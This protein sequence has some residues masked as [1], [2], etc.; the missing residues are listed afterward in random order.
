MSGENAIKLTQLVLAPGDPK[1]MAKLNDASPMPLDAALNLLR[2]KQNVIKMDIPISGNIND[3]NID[4]SDAIGQAIGTIAGKAGMAALTTVGPAAALGPIGLVAIV[5]KMGVDQLAKVRLASI[6]YAP[7]SSDRPANSDKALQD[8]ATVLEKKQELNLRLCPFYTLEDAQA[9]ASAAG[10]GN[11]QRSPLGTHQEAIAQL[12]K[13]RAADLKD[14]L[15]SKYKLDHKR[16]LT[17]TPELDDS[18][19]GKPRVEFGL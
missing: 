16:I 8:T 6:E 5:G 11:A 9:V 14:L 7:G 15:V 4:V 19:S 13:K 1:V 17:C 18:D 3:P 2:D 12:S 10:D